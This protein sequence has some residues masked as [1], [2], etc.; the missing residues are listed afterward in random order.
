MRQP[1]L[2]TWI[3]LTEVCQTFDDDVIFQMI[4]NDQDINNI[5][6]LDKRT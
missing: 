2:D 6:T 1:F 3:K 5:W 4:S